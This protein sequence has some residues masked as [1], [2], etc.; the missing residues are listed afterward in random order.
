MISDMWLT[1]DG[2]DVHIRYFEGTYSDGYHT[3]HHFRMD[4][5]QITAVPNW[6]DFKLEHAILAG[7]EL[8]EI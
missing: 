5:R 7:R 8:K 4:L 3:N 2:K 1:N 6:C